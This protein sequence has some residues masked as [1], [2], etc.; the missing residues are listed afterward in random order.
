MI[1]NYEDKPI[2][3][4]MLYLQSSVQKDNMPFGYEARYKEEYRRWYVR[5]GYNYAYDIDGKADLEGTE[6]E[7]F[8]FWDHHPNA[9]YKNTY[10]D[11]W[12]GD[13]IDGIESGFAILT[14]YN[15]ALSR[16]IDVEFKHLTSAELDALEHA[17]YI[18]HMTDILDC[19]DLPVSIYRGEWSDN[20]YFPKKSL[21]S[22]EE[23]M[24]TEDWSSEDDIPFA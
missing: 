19:K 12:Y 23:D 14:E 2:I 3:G 1:Y 24:L 13:A 6:L 10:G 8:L 18:W 7:T 16:S 5:G 22:E 20:E 15:G 11:F 4:K 9:D 17:F 21:D